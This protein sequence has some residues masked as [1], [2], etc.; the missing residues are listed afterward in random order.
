LRSQLLCGHQN[1]LWGIPHQITL[2][3]VNSFMVRRAASLPFALYFARCPLS[4]YGPADSKYIYIDAV[5]CETVTRETLLRYTLNSAP[6][7][8][9]ISGNLW[10]KLP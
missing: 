9:L 3:F 6:V 1:E 4:E 2:L 7:N 10:K 8:N 5:R